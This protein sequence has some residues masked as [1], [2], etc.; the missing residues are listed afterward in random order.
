MKNI[1]W[2]KA[3]E[4]GVKVKTLSQT[5]LDK[6]MKKKDLKKLAKKGIKKNEISED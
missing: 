4:I 6:L 1:I 3:K 2:E 5:R